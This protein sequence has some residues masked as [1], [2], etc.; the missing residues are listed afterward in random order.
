MENRY[1]I[2]G[3]VKFQQ[4]VNALSRISP[5]AE[6]RRQIKKETIEFSVENVVSILESGLMN[7]I[8][9]YFQNHRQGSYYAE[10]D[11]EYKVQ[12]LVFCLLFQHISDLHFENPAPKP[13][14]GLTHVIVDFSS[15]KLELLIEVKHIS[16]KS[17]AKEVEREISE[18]IVKYGKSRKF[19]SLIF[20]VYCHNYKLPNK[21]QFEAGFSGNQSIQ[22][23]NF[24]TVCI[25]N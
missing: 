5:P 13:K 2:N 3:V 16:S 15:N 12:D 20:F 10:I 14:G 18:D 9:G 6:I 19:K 7:D 24:E 1:F 21:R 23:T 25:V 11:N 17:K 4:L 8:I 22:S